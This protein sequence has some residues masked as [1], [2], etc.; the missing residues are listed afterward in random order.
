MFT[1]TTIVGG[2]VFEDYSHISNYISESYANGTTYG[3]W[4]RWIG[5]IPSGLFIALFSMLAGRK[6]KG[7]VLVFYG[8]IGFGIL[9]GLFTSLVSV[10][11]CDLGCNRDEG[12]ASTSQHIH[13]ILS[14]FTYLVTPIMLFMIGV[15]FKGSNRHK[16]ISR[17]T[18]VLSF[19]ALAFGLLFLINANS[20]IAGLLQRLTESIFLFWILYI[21]VKLS[22]ES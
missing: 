8:F 1:V 6:F 12:D 4:L 18:L 20:A 16:T 11:P 21:S 14:L 10:F 7:N 9:Y 5:Y 3:P 17:L 13:T 15:G 22:K 2:S 19:T